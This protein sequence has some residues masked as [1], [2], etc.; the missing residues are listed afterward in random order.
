MVDPNSTPCWHVAI[1]A[2]LRDPDGRTLQNHKERPHGLDEVAQRVETALSAEHLAAPLQVERAGSVQALFR[3]APGVT[4]ALSELGDALHPY[5]WVVG[6]GF[7]LVE[8]RFRGT[9]VVLDGSALD[10]ARAAL[11]TARRDRRGAMAVGFGSPDDETIASLVEMMDQTRS[12]WTERQAETI[13]AARR[14]KGKEVAARFGVSP[15]V[16]SES[17]KAASFRPL[18]RAENALAG[19]LDRYG[20]DGP[21][22]GESVVYPDI[23]SPLSRESRL[24]V[25]RR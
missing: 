17:L 8:A 18:T 15:S 19:L 2:E 5:R 13:R 9:T 6:L 22:R 23:L 16:V 21:W 25:S 12:R 11:W 1:A 7:G 4:L 24:L 14:H 10:R 20:T 3:R